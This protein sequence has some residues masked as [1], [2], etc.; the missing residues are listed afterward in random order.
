MFQ[1]IYHNLM[2]QRELVHQFWDNC[3]DKKV[4]DKIRSEEIMAECWRL[5][6]L[7][8]LRSSRRTC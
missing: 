8:A 5:L 3:M 1:N 6:D 4:A 7:L 2:P